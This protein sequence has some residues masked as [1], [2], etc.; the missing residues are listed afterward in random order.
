MCSVC[1]WEKPFGCAYASAALVVPS[2]AVASA[3]LSIG[4][5]AHFGATLIEPSWLIGVKHTGVELG[6]P[7]PLETTSGLPSSW[8]SVIGASVDT[9]EYVTGAAKPP[10]PS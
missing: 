2:F 9:F 8:P 3:A 7:P 5:D 4:V 10:F 6:V 1:G